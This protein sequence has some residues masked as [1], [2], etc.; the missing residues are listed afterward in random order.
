MDSNSG[1][2]AVPLEW[3]DVHTNRHPEREAVL[4]DHSNALPQA[5]E[6]S[7]FPGKEAAN[8]TSGK[9]QNRRCGLR[10]RIFYAVLLSAIVLIVGVIAGGVAGGLRSSRA[11]SGGRTSVP[12]N[13]TG[14][15]VTSSP[16]VYILAE[17]RLSASNW[18]DPSG[19]NHR[20]IFFQD[21]SNAIIARRWDSYKRVW[22]TNNLTDIMRSAGTPIN[23]LS[24]STPLASLAV[25]NPDDW[26]YDNDVKASGLAASPGSQLAAAW[27]RCG[28]D[29]QCSGYSAVAYQRS[30]DGAI[31]VSGI[32]VS[33]S[34]GL[35]AVDT[36][37][38]AQNSTGGLLHKVVLPAPSSQLQFAISTTD[39][40]YSPVF[41]GLL[42]NGTVTCEYYKGSQKNFI[43]VPVVQFRGGPSAVNFSAI[44]AS[45]EGLFYGISND[46]I[47]EYSIEATARTANFY[48]VQTVYP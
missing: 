23:P 6:P 12:D 20:F 31:S 45:E 24:Q 11:H 17:S 26:A 38:V 33:D 39:S 21:T 19:T 43:S 4:N 47:L 9:E 1:L 35:L 40:F 44:A 8:L 5:I 46:G 10:P 2:E 15:N 48:F 27:N 16:N 30:I 22:A 18:T 3:R 14:G 42:P 25:A 41:L 36:R 37:G 7:S 34:S 32:N 29:D 28:I 13:T